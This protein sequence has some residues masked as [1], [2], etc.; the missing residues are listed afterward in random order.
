MVGIGFDIH[1]FGGE[2]PLIIGGVFISS[3][4]GVKAHS[5]GDVLIHALIDALLGA[6][7]K[8]D[9]GELFPDTDLKWKDADSSQLLRYVLDEIKGFVIENIDAVIVIDEP[10][11]GKYKQQI[12]ENLSKIL[13]IAI[14][15]IGIKA[16][17]SEGLMKDAVSAMVV[18]E[19]EEGEK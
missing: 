19:L 1:R 16:K 7:G 10:K 2:K 4:I 6:T 13:N 17:T 18:V 3:D 5:D 9:I 12:K 11:L 14:D 8:G 15:K